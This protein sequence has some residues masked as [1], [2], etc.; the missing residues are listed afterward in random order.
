MC[1]QQ[2]VR[3]KVGDLRPAER[4]GWRGA[5]SMPEARKVSAALF[6]REPKLGVVAKAARH[7]SKVGVL[8]KVLLGVLVRQSDR[9]QAAFLRR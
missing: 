9:P 4:S 5:F 8:A 1:I 2:V 3:C 7:V 6:E